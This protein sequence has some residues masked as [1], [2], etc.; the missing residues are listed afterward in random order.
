MKKSFTKLERLEVYNKYDGRCAYCGEEINLKD[1]QIDHIICKRNFISN[2]KNNKQPYFLKHL[3]EEDLNHNDNLNPSCR[4]CNK[5]KD[6]FTL[7]G[8]RE[9]VENQILYLNKYS[10]TYRTAKK[11]NL[12]E[13]KQRKIVFYFENYLQ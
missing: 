6:A 10:S 8:F 11:Y 13:E 4:V 3:T 9:Q 5:R 12:L 2:I 7:D 1:M